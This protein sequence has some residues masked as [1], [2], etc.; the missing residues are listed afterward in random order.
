MHRILLGLKQQDL[1]LWTFGGD[2]LDF[3][4]S[5]LPS[6][7]QLQTK[8][9]PPLPAHLQRLLVSHELSGSIFP[10]A[11]PGP[12]DQTSIRSLNLGCHCVLHSA[13]TS[14][15]WTQMIYDLSATKRRSISDQ[16]LKDLRHRQALVKGNN[17]EEGSLQRQYSLVQLILSLQGPISGLPNELLGEIFLVS[18]EQLGVNQDTLQSVCRSWGALITHIWGELQVGTWTDTQQIVRVV[19][20]GPQLLDVV[21]DT[22]MDE[23]TS[24]ALETPYAALAIV[25]ASA[26]RWRSLTINSFPSRADILASNI[27]YNPHTSYRNLESLAVGRGC[28]L[29]D[30]ME[31]IIR[32]I[33]TNATPT[34][35]SL[36]FAATTAFQRFN[37][38]YL[39]CIYPHLTVLEVHV[40]RLGEPVDLLCR[41]AR[42]EVMKLSGV[43]LHPPSPNNKLPFLQTLR[44]L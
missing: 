17:E 44:C 24:I 32:A 25:W 36:T 14:P 20:Q 2:L 28:D 7:E 43:L 1:P 40:V 15:D 29:S 42:L 5:V 16:L 8:A 34:L 11:L 23:A 4:F 18:V 39:V 38:P 22:G 19:N 13:F 21:I 3:T 10:I 27:P 33:T 9:A 31:E 30:A 6:T 37:T 12:F 26:F 41:C 35:T